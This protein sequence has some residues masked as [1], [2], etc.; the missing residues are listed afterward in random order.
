MAYRAVDHHVY[1]SVRRFLRRRPKVN[2]RDTRRFSDAEIFGTYGVLR[3][4]RVHLAPL[5][6]DTLAWDS[7][8]DDMR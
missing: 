7:K 5:P 8:P 4:G 6:N 3:L 1:E 2:T